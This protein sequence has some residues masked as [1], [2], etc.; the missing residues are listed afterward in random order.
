MDDE[1]LALRG[2]RDGTSET[3]VAREN[4]VIV[5]EQIPPGPARNIAGLY[6][7]LEA[8]LNNG[9]R[10]D[11]DFDTAVGL[12]HLLGALEEASESGKRQVVAA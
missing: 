10:I 9:A 11:P 8:A 6:V 1:P 3:I 2:T 5:P 12:H 7:A 4:R